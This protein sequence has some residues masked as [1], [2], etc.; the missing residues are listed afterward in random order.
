MTSGADVAI[1]LIGSGAETTPGAD[2]AES[3]TG[4]ETES[5]FV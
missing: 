4:L 2:V 3:L 5:T 1:S